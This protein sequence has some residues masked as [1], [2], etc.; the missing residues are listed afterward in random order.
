MG[1]HAGKGDNNINPLPV[2]SG[3]VLNSESSITMRTVHG[4]GS[5][6]SDDGEDDDEAEETDA[7]AQ[8]QQQRRT[9]SYINSQ[10]TMLYDADAEYRD[11]YEYEHEGESSSSSPPLKAHKPL[12]GPDELIPAQEI[13]VPKSGEPLEG[14]RTLLMWLPAIFDVSSLASLSLCLAS[15]GG[16]RLLAIDWQRMQHTSKKIKVSTAMRRTC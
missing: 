15:C 13:P 16:R 8:Q 12:V 9:S 5:G 14:S 3:V 2:D 6:R 10:Q 4:G 11:E 1:Q 7:F